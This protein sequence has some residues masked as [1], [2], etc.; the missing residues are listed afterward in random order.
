LVV[1]GS[2]LAEREFIWSEALSQ[3]GSAQTPRDYLAAAATYQKLVDCGARNATVFYNQGT[4]LLLAG[5][6]P[7]AIQVLHRAER[8]GGSAPDLRRN[9]AIARGRLEG[10]KSPVTS[11][12][13]MA[14]FWH[15]G[16]SCA[17]RILIVAVAFALLWIAGALRLLGSKN[18]A[19]SLSAVAL[20]VFLLFGASVLTSL[21]QEG[22]AARPAVLQGLD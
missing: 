10:L 12:Q 3:M 5:K 7:E 2:T 13:Q 21:Q 20:L 22:Q 4:A 15:Y 17:T 9:L 6:Y 14:L 8:Y 11:W 18:A 19:R 1:R 16:L